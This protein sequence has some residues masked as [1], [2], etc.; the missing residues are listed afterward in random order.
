MV[1][2]VT[3]SGDGCV[4]AIGDRYG[5]ADLTGFLMAL[6]KPAHWMVI[7]DVRQEMGS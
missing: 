4:A 2:R 7:T 5:Q 3:L 1:T 6:L